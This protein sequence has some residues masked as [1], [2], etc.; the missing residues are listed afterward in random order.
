MKLRP[1]ALITC[2]TLIV[3]V[4]VL[5]GDDVN[6]PYGLTTLAGKQAWISLQ[7]DLDKLEAQYQ[8]DRK[9]RINQGITDLERAKVQAAQAANADEIVRLDKAVTELKQGNEVTTTAGPATTLD[10]KQLQRD[11]DD[12]RERLIGTKW[13]TKLETYE[14]YDGFVIQ[15]G[16][17]QLPWIPLD[18]KRLAVSGRIFEMNEDGTGAYQAH[19]EWCNQ[20]RSRYNE[21][22]N[23]NNRNLM[24]VK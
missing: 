2:I 6:N 21:P 8:R 22:I 15:N 19:W 12:L 18:G 3:T 17:D 24:R 14:F 23:G 1:R 10:L 11:R 20:Y 5:A 9:V 13:K 7:R 16:K 4:T